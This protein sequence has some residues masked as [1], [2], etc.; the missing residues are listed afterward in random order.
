MT[1]LQLGRQPPTALLY[2]VF[3][4]INRTDVSVRQ[5]S[6]WFYVEG[7][8]AR[9]AHKGGRNKGREPYRLSHGNYK[10]SS[11]QRTAIRMTQPC[12]E[13]DPVIFRGHVLVYYL[14]PV[15]LLIYY[16]KRGIMVN[17]GMFDDAEK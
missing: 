12:L 3:E 2:R 7:R 8:R 13:I 6:Y 4:I 9:T 1:Y 17:K 5:R 16:L 15:T 10:F 14:P 11:V